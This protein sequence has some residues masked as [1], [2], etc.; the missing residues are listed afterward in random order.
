[1]RRLRSSFGLGLADTSVLVISIDLSPTGGYLATGSGDWQARVCEYRL[2]RL[3]PERPLNDTFYRELQPDMILRLSMHASYP[4]L[5]LS[6]SR[7][8][9][10][11]SGSQIFAFPC[12]YFCLYQLLPYQISVFSE[13]SGVAEQTKVTMNSNSTLMTD[14]TSPNSSVIPFPGL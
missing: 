3:C 4:N 12:L 1:M 5:S 14:Q 9:Q 11:L 6:F 13:C 2:T 8:L 10:V 7:I